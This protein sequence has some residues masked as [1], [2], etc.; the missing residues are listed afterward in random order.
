[1]SRNSDR[2]DYHKGILRLINRHY[3][4]AMRNMPNGFQKKRRAK[5]AAHYKQVILAA[6]TEIEYWETKK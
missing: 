6:K 4:E 2:A 3:R 1:M 5:I